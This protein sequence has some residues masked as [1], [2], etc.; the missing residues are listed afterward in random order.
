MSGPI[1]SN[2]THNSQSAGVVKRFFSGLAKKLGFS[3]VKY[4]TL[5]GGQMG[6]LLL[7]K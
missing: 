7:R 6:I 4:K 3:S 1:Q 5:F 2:N